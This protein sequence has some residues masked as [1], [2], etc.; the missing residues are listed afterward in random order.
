VLAINEVLLRS[1]LQLF[2][3]SIDLAADSD[4][5]LTNR[6]T[7]LVVETCAVKDRSHF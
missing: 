7:S 3:E 5:F 2:P 4:D 6:V 1:D